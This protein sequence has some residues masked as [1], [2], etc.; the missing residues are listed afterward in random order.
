MDQPS[1]SPED[2]ALHDLLNALLAED[3][4]AGDVTTEAIVHADE[5]AVGRLVAKC[6]LV[7]AGLEIFLEVFRLLD[8]NLVTKVRQKDGEWIT[9]GESSVTLRARARALLSGERVALNLLQR[10]SGVA[11]LTRKYVERVSGTDVRIFDTRKTTPG[12]RA[13]E[14]YAVTAGGGANHR[15][16]LNDAILIKENHIHLAGG[17]QPAIHAARAARHKARF[18]EV[19]IT[20]L[21]ELREALEEFPD[22]IL[23]DNMTPETV[24][25]AV[26]IARARNDQ[27]VLEASGGI[28]L[29]NVREYAEAGV[30]RISA[31]ALTHSAPA[32]DLSLEIEPIRN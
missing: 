4:G 30:N 16:G 5:M 29:E 3:L 14:K 15:A 7:L 2:S 17:I 32:V 28:T 20:T 24:Q 18:L 12:L 31:G 13:L 8:K 11:T 6:P 26:R 25:E 23:L 9:P 1:H 27:I 10:L 22:I 19:E 21:D